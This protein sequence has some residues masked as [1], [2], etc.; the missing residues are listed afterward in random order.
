M[1]VTVGFDGQQ[2]F[3][4]LGNGF[5]DKLNVAREGVQIDFNPV[6]ACDE[7]QIGRKL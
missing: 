3:G 1:A 6:R 4:L 7:I 5:A 2:N